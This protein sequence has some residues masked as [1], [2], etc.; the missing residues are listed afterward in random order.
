MPVSSRLKFNASAQQQ[1]FIF[2]LAAASNEIP[3][4][5]AA[6]LQLKPIGFHA[7]NFKPVKTKGFEAF[8]WYNLH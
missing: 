8:D 1:A 4:S 5:K 6:A 2:C 7:F 3:I